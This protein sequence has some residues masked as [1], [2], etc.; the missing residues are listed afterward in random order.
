MTKH[1]VTVWYDG[2]CP[3]CAAEIALMRRLDWRSAVQFV[4]INANIAACPVDPRDMLKRLHA[5][6]EGKLVSGAAAF[7]AM[8][9]ALPLLKPLGKA[10]RNRAV[11]GLL[12]NAY[13]F[14]LRYRPRLQRAL[15][16]LANAFSRMKRI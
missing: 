4:E 13:V 11:L 9:R 14:F 12:E 1:A 5:L 16:S 6:E 3:L 10:A 2:Q 8:W 7:A 15:Y